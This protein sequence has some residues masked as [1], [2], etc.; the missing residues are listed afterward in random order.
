[1]LRFLNTLTG[2]AY[3]FGNGKNNS[4]M[5]ISTIRTIRNKRTNV[6][7]KKNILTFWAKSLNRD[8]GAAVTTVASADS[9]DSKKT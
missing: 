2:I 3:Q 7:N 9:T 5:P 6:W 1:M 4:N 8:A